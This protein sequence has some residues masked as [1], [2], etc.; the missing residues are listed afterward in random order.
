ML[1]K[2]RHSTIQDSTQDLFPIEIFLD[3][4]IDR[5]K[6]SPDS[7]RG[8]VFTKTEV[9]D[10]MLDLAGYTSDRPLW[11]MRFLEPSFGGGDFLLR[12]V[13]RLLASSEGGVVSS[14][15]LRSAIV[16]VELH[17]DTFLSTSKKVF[18]L[19]TAAG[20]SKVEAMELT[21]HWLTNT[22]FLLKPFGTDFDF[23]VGNPPYVRQE[24]IPV[25]LLSEYRKRYTT[26]FDRADLYVPFMQ[27]SLQL[28]KPTGQLS[29]ICSDRWMKNR[30]GGPLRRLIADGYTLL[31][32][33]D[34][35][36][37]PA[38][39]SDV[40]AY[41][42]ITVIKRGK[43]SEAVRVAYRPE[44]STESL[45]HLSR[46][47]RGQSSGFHGEVFVVV[48]MPRGE[49]PWLLES[50]AQS[51]LTLVRRL[52]REFPILEESGCTVGIGVA[53]GADKIFIGPLTELDVEDERKLPLVTTR[54][55]VSGKVKWRGLGVVNPF[56]DNGQ[57]ADFTQYPRF[58][59]Y[60]HKHRDTLVKR[61]CAQKA[62]RSWYRT[63]DR[64]TPSLAQQPKL[65]IPDIKGEANI[66]LDES[67][68]YPHHNLYYITSRE[69]P[70]VALERVLS[71]GIAQLFV[72]A[73]STKMRGG[74]LRFQA[75]Y[76]R[77][78]RLP[79]WQSLP[80]TIQ[81]TLC[82]TSKD[83]EVDTNA[84]SIMHAVMVAYGLNKEDW[85]HLIH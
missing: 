65:L 53:T 19:L 58:A 2:F 51:S 36:D 47:L 55:I 79:R 26:L 11:E 24:L 81:E 28:L 49:E 29:F 30:Y 38:F 43:S 62:N 63:I 60:M 57:L 50:D 10:F 14:D 34:M 70:I 39:Q 32:Y 35:V 27:R 33:V 1:T 85:Y 17:R 72:R 68:L 12:A 78:I 54:D 56:E 67:G 4:T 44:I 45:S 46:V 69:W 22:D 37:T 64:I 84:A 66:V 20:I 48:E 75:Q 7:E 42:A 6:M 74:C 9:V 40:V 71:S 83:V 8:A 31:F 3:T 80:L 21:N 15:R 23:V 5:M 77:R 41:P 13:E 16:G 18:D 25:E 59:A 61:H 73:Y 82:T 76:L 52:E